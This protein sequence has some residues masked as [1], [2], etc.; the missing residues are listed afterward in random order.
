MWLTNKR[1]GNLRQASVW[2]FLIAFM[3]LFRFVYYENSHG[4][5]SDYITFSWIIPLVMTLL[6][7]LLF[8]LNIDIGIY[9]RYCLNLATALLIIYLL[10][11][12]V[13][14]IALTSSNW[15]ITFLVLSILAYIASIILL[16]VTLVKQ[17][18]KNAS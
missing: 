10:I 12:G 15:L 1:I 16:I 9:T 3:F 13:Y 2:T 4:V 7:M 18:M 14:E 17:K 11:S 8:L 5:Y 6:F